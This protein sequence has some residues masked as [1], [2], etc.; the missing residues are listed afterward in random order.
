MVVGAVAV[1]VAVV[2]VILP[3]TSAGSVRRR[4]RSSVAY[5]AAA[6]VQRR[7]SECALRGGMQLRQWGQHGSA[8]QRPRR[9]S[10]MRRLRRA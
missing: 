7:V 9:R 3:L 4:C 5:A 6:A 10:G 1:A 2:V 8:H